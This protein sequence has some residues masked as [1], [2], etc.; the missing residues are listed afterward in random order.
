MPAP[1]TMPSMMLTT[2]H[3]P[4]GACFDTASSAECAMKRLPSR[5]RE[6]PRQ[7][8]NLQ[9]CGSED[10][11]SIQL[12]YG[13]LIPERLFANLS[14]IRVPDKRGIG[15]ALSVPFVISDPTSKIPRPGTVSCAPFSDALHAWPQFTPREEG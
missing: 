3:R 5:E 7:D 13:G 1:T 4:R 8:L 12:S 11:C 10:R 2:S 14:R 15:L 6:Y 9:T